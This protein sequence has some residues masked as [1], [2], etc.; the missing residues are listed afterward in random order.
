MKRLGKWIGMLILVIL[1]VSLTALTVCAQEG[2][3]CGEDLTWTLDN[4]GTLTVS[5]QGSMPSYAN[6]PAPWQQL[7]VKTVVIEDGVTN[8]GSY[9][10][11][12]CTA[13]THVILGDTVECI[14]PY[15]F[16]YCSRLESIVI[17]NSVY[18]VGRSAFYSCPSLKEIY[19][20]GNRSDW[21]NLAKTNNA[22]INSVKIHYNYGTPAALHIPVCTVAPESSTIRISWNPVEGAELYQVL[23]RLTYTDNWR[24]IGYTA[25]TSYIYENPIYQKTC[26]FSVRCVSAD[27]STATSAFNMVGWGITY[28]PTPTVTKMENT[29]EGIRITWDPVEGVSRYR[30]YQITEAGRI[31]EG[32]V[33]G[34]TFLFR[35]AVSGQ[36]YTFTVQA[37]KETGSS[38]YGSMNTTG[39]TQTYVAE[40]AIKRFENTAEGIKISWDPV[41][42]AAK[43]RLFVK[44]AKGWK[45]LTIT[46]GLSY[47]YSDARCGNAYTFTIRCV[48]AAGTAFTG[49]YNSTG[50]KYVYYEPPV[51]TDFQNT[52]KG[53]RI[54]WDKVTRAAGYRVF[55]KNA[56]GSWQLLGHTTGNSFLWTG[57]KSG[58]TYTFTVRCVNTANTKF[59][60]FYNTAGWQHKYIAVPK[61]TELQNAATGI[62]IAWNPVSGAERY[63]VYVKT[64]NTGWQCIG[65]TTKTAVFWRGAQAG[66]KYTFT[67]RCVNSA[68]TAFTSAFDPTGW[69]LIRS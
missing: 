41:P 61:V 43:Y 6:E 7:P 17:P 29:A 25:D 55:V 54:T 26:Y 15:S 35:Q 1:C 18:Y 45:T 16:S 59:T 49:S 3:S 40:P 5:G 57:A 68:N 19:Y 69:S 44:T 36:S 27:Q 8:V 23:Y 38:S 20:S 21:K 67:V 48:N 51:I 13:L 37:L 56:K 39:W 42:G 52:A 12:D 63:R 28:Y 47:L 62:R 58:E 53:I 65:H 31:N 14:N 33:T 30:V 11:S 64:E 24:C 9:A 34:T 4:T 22:N 32:V 50:W 66:V 60:S 10:F 46:D 2:G